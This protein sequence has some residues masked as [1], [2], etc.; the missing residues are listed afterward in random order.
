MKTICA[1]LVLFSALG[2]AASCASEQGMAASPTTE[3]RMS[4][5]AAA[6]K[7]AAAECDK[8]QRCNN[9]GSGLKY[10]SRQ[11]CIDV[12]GKEINNDFGA[13][14]DCLNGVAMDDLNECVETLKT[15]DCGGVTAPV[16]SVQ[17]TMMC[18]SN[19]LCLD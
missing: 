11:H 1:S 17:A 14:E 9:I 8:E 5:A 13:D 19:A 18:R 3:P 12:L 16:E 7:V 2:L 6:P 10:S 4:A 15:E